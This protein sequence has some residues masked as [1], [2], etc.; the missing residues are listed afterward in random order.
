MPKEKGVKSAIKRIT[1][2]FFS[3]FLLWKLPAAFFMGVR[4]KSLDEKSCSVSVP[5]FWLSQNP[6]RSIY[7]V[8]L[9]AAAEMSTGLL[10]IA[11]IEG[12]PKISML[13]TGIEGEFS[14]KAVTK[15]TFTCHQGEAIS[16][17][18]EKAVSTGEGQEIEIE[19]IGIQKTGEEVARFTLKW[20]FKVKP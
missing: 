20:S 7:F 4:L 9:S 17:A 5:F 15:T 11:H 6:F 2:P 14:K 13:I 16:Q 12:K 10:A 1:G 8:A 3:T 19:S 18:I